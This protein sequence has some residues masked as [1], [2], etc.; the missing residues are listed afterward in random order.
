MQDV[1]V[2]QLIEKNSMTRLSKNYENKLVNKI[3]NAFTNNEQ[4]I[5]LSSFYCFL[6]YD[7]K[8][9]FV[10]D[11]DKVWKWLGFSRK[12]PA[13]RVLEKN[14]TENFD[15]NILRNLPQNNFE[16]VNDFEIISHQTVGNKN[17]KLAPQ[18]GGASF[19]QQHGGQNK[20][21]IMLTVNTFK[22]FCLKA[23]TSKADEVHDYY[24]KL[25]ELLQETINEE[26]N[27]LRLQLSNK[28]EE[29]LRIEE[30]KN[31]LEEENKKLIKKYVKK[32]KEIFENKNV[33]YLMTTDEAEKNKEYVVGKAFDLTRRKEDYNHN[34]LH[35]FKVVYYVCCKGPKIMDCLESLILSKLGKYRC[36]AGRD[37]FC[38]PDNNDI[39]LFTNMFDT[40]FKMYDD[41]NDD[42]IRYPVATKPHLLKDRKEY[43]KKYYQENIDDIKE[44]QKLFYENNKDIISLLKKIYCKENADKISERRK[45]YYQEHKDEIIK[46]RMEYYNENKDNILEKRKEYY[47]NNKESILEKREKYYK[48]NYETKIALK[49]QELVHC[50]CGMTITNYSVNK[51]KKTKKHIERMKNVNEPVTSKLKERLTTVKNI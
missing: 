36:K 33:V 9:D 19:E 18:L 44:N 6:N 34:K 48:E 2:I 21:R 26:T 50:E 13:K 5:F 46:D 31:K 3:K 29:K 14:F 47:E 38:I 17:T 30:E 4:Q 7:S 41:V 27:E 45:K 24:I 16:T 20:E 12:D 32:E 10:V 1:N 40:C 23:G 49:R 42:D 15:Y 8:K 22:K 51:H 28:E 25:E 11:F 35:D 43:K 37:A 39:S